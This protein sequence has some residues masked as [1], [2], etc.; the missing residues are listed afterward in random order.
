MRLR[1]AIG[2]LLSACCVLS[3]SGPAQAGF[4]RS[5]ARGGGGGSRSGGSGRGGERAIVHTDPGGGGSRTRYVPDNRGDS[6]H[7]T[8]GR[9]R[10]WRRPDGSVWRRSY[11][12]WGYGL[13]WQPLVVAPAPVVVVDTEGAAPVYEE[14]PAGSAPDDVEVTLTG[15]VALT[16]D[17]QLLGTQL[18]IDGRHIGGV[19]GYTAVFLPVEGGEPPDR[20]HLMHAR[21]SWP[22]AATPRFRMR[23]ELG[24]HAAVA[25]LASFFAPGLGV[26]AA[27]ALIGPLGLEARVFGNAWPYTQVDARAGVTLSFRR[28]GLSVGWRALYLNDQ[29][30]LGDANAGD[31]DDFF[32]GPSLVLAL[33]LY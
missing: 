14:D 20:L 9:A 29:G 30:R 3:V 31:T 11:R 10:D 16:R 18:V 6:G 7:A 12:P 2:L 22:L 27:L 32:S 21:L 23:A 19:L 15:D 13:Q 25:P 24:A 5:R 1:V 4:G 33:A 8:T 28:V 17:A 26:S